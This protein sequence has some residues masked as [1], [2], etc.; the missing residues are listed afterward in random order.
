[1]ILIRGDWTLPDKKIESFLNS[2][3]RFGVPFNV[4][5]SYNLPEGIVMSEILTK[6]AIKEAL[7][8]INEEK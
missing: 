2:F 4:F 1:M 6:K 7:N 8:K 5:F 3:N